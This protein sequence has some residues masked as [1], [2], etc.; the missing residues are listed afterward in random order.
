MTIERMC[1]IKPDD[2]KSA[3][4]S[5]NACGSSTIVPLKEISN[6]AALLERNCIVCG[7]PT[8]FKKDSREW[9]DVLLFGEKL[10]HLSNTMKARG[11]TYTL[12]IECPAE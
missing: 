10:G 7:S 3:K 6:I 5:C 1:F 8:G 2:V 9:Q 4:I 11:I 12:R